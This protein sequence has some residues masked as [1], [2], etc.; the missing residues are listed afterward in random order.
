MESLFLIIE[1]SVIVEIMSYPPPAVYTFY[2][3]DCLSVGVPPSDDRNYRPLDPLNIPN[4]N[5][6]KQNR[7]FLHVERLQKLSF[8]VVN[9]TDYNEN[10]ETLVDHIN[11]ESL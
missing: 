11:Q 10:E 5:Q 4:F 2:T 3:E 1:Y 8:R 6:Q 7:S 9:I